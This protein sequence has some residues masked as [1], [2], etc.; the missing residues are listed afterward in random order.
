MNNWHKDAIA[1]RFIRA[2]GPG[3]QNV[4]KVATAVQLRFDIQKASLSEEVQTRLIKLAGK[5][6]TE[7]KILIITAQRFRTQNRNR[8]DALE[9]LMLLIKLARQKPKPRKKT[10]VPKAEKQQRVENK[11]RRSQIK[12]W[13]RG[14]E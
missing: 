4:N 1:L 11:K 6:I 8:E 2:A 7:N 13:R 12:K 3:G 14:S 5:R 10:K 9:R